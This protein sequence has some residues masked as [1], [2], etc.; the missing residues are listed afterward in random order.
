MSTQRFVHKCS[1]QLFPNSLKLETI[2][3]SI[4]R[5]MDKQ[6]VVHPFSGTTQQQHGMNYQ[7]KKMDQCTWLN[8]GPPKDVPMF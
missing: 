8:G 6:I 2:Q 3:M 5:Q 4:K 7:S 1:E